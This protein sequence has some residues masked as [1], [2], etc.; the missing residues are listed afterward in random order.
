MTLQKHHLVTRG[1]VQSTAAI[2]IKV[3]GFFEEQSMETVIL[4]PISHRWG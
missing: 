3:A 1:G 4:N 2:D